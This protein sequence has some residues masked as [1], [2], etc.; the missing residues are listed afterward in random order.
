MW[1]KQR[2]GLLDMFKWLMGFCRISIKKCLQQTQSQFSWKAHIFRTP[3]L[4]PAQEDISLQ[5]FTLLFFL[6]SLFL[7]SISTHPFLTRSVCTTET[8]D[9]PSISSSFSLGCSDYSYVHPTWLATTFP[10]CSMYLSWASKRCHVKQTHR[11]YYVSFFVIKINTSA[12][13]LL[14]SLFTTHNMI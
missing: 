10:S 4:L 1:E 3:E 8:N 12:M 2:T 5:H 14:I 7:L 6:S 13:L 11:V 9:T